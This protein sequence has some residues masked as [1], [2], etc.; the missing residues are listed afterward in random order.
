[1][2]ILLSPAKTMDFE[3]DSARSKSSKP[4]MAD[5]ARVLNLLLR[6][7]SAEEL[8]KLMKL[9]PKLAA[10]NLDRNQEWVANPPRSRA[11]QS[12]QA[13]QGA[14]FA[15]LDAGSFSSSDWDYSQQHLAILSGLYGVLRPLDLMMPYRLEMGT[16]LT[17]PHGA[18]LYQYWGERIADQVEQ[19]VVKQ[20]DEVII[21]LASKE[22][23]KAVD[24]EQIQS[25]VIEL[26]FKER[27]GDAFKTIGVHAKHARGLMARYIL[28]EQLDHPEQLKSFTD[29]GYEF[30]QGLSQPA[31]LVFTRG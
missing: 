13:F 12:L 17:N 19:L 28:L 26:Q 4:L 2:L 30:N 27:K 24:H 3:A 20:G 5:D 23:F 22:Y 9:S 8:G 11:R 15:A 18:N 6:E 31:Q 16:R 1:M 25:K 21:N 29:E 10:L 7:L 14:V